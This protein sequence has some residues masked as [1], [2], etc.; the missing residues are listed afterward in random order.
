MNEREMLARDLSER[1]LARRVAILAIDLEEI[2]T[3]KE[4][5]LSSEELEVLLERSGFEV[6]EALLY[7]ENRKSLEHAVECKR[8]NV[9]RA[10]NPLVHELEYT[11]SFPDRNE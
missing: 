10:L 5:M 11:I 9:L 4:K 3:L 1:Q 2:A 8:R 7:I 6:K